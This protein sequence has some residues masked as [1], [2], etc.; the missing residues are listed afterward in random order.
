MEI[1]PLYF[2]RL[3]GAQVTHILDWENYLNNKENEYRTYLQA[4]YSMMNEA[5]ELELLWVNINPG[6]GNILRLSSKYDLLDGLS[7]EGG[8]IFYQSQNTSSAIYSYNEQ[9]RLFLRIKY[10]F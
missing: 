3:H 7:I 2:G 5:L 8:I 9:D 10:S 4:T 1:R 6:H